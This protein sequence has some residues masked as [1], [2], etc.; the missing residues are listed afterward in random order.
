MATNF[1]IEVERFK[2]VTT[3]HAY[4]I[5]DLGRIYSKKRKR[6]LSGSV[7]HY[8]YTTVFVKENGKW[9][10]RFVHHLV[11]EA[12]VG[13]R[14]DKYQINHKDGIKLNN[15]LANLEYCTVSENSIHALRTGLRKSK[16]GEQH[17]RSKLSDLQIREIR[18]QLEN[19][20][21]L[22]G[23]LAKKYNVDPSRISHIKHNPD[24]RKTT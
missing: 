19:P 22:Q 8:G 14:P 7:S 23:D 5:S 3:N 10:N 15:T 11:M 6:F 2:P 16:S 18:I 24:F 13:L 17:G 4:F 20:T 9:K 12:F 1:K 21:M